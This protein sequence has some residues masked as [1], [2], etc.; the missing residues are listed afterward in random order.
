MAQNPMD[1]FNSDMND[2]FNQLMGGMNGSAN[3]RYMING[4]E[5][6]PEEFAQYRQNGQ[7]PGGAMPQKGGQPGPQPS[8]GKESILHKL[9]RNKPVKANWTL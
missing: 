3:R 5:V 2:I 7:L 9:G 8:E 1:P 6:T 4:Q